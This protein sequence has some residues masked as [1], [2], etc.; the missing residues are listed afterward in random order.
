MKMLRQSYSSKLGAI[1]ADLNSP[2]C[3]VTRVLIGF[4]H[5]G[6]AWI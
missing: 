1:R 3:S 6:F 5:K 4:N 2:F